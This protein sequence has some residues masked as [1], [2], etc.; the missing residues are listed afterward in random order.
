MSNFELISIHLINVIPN[1]KTS[2]GPMPHQSKKSEASEIKQIHI[3][4][5]L[6]W[7]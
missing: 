5:T 7:F 6:H 4:L 1:N 2:D 3:S